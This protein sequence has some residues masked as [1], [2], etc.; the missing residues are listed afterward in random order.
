MSGE[1]RGKR[2]G[3]PFGGR[4]LLR[5]LSKCGSDGSRHHA[6]LFH[7]DVGQRVGIK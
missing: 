1:T 4:L 3:S 5:L 2:D 7:V 6:A